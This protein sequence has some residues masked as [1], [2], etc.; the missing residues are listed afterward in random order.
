VS[1][2][3]RTQLTALNAVQLIFH[4]HEVFAVKLK[5]DL[6]NCCFG[7]SDVLSIRRVLLSV[8]IKNFGCCNA[9]ALQLLMNRLNGCQLL[10]LLGV[11]CFIFRAF[12]LQ[13]VVEGLVLLLQCFGLV[14]RTLVAVYLADGNTSTQTRDRL[15]QADIRSVQ[16]RL[17]LHSNAFV[18]FRHQQR[19]HTVL[20]RSPP[21]APLSFVQD[22]WRPD[23][24]V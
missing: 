20:R 23:R 5:V 13:V 3:V 8:G 14:V 7:A 16:R 21:C 9:V 22:L 18:I 2:A 6:V 10:L 24:G 19:V 12:A 4:L 17:C 15:Y 11:L 1:E